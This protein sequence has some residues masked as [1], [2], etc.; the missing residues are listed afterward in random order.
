MTTV[1]SGFLVLAILWVIL[2]PV[3]TFAAS[4]P[5]SVSSDVG[6]ALAFVVYRIGSVVCHQRPE[7]SLHLFAAQMPVCARCTGIYLGA[8]LTAIV[9]A[10]RGLDETVKKRI[11]AGNAGTIEEK[12]QSLL[13]ALCGKT[14]GVFTRAEALRGASRPHVAPGLGPARRVLLVSVLPSVATLVYEWS[15][16]Q[17]P[18]HWVRATSGVPLGAAVA[19]I[20][21]RAAPARR[22][23]M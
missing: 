6:Q 10:F 15:T 2:L 5:S 17:M 12:T 3:A 7:R 23:G 18:A 22:E 11:T 9:V 1:R 8:A 19:W 21:C 16:G 4:R 13:G 14:A 20:V